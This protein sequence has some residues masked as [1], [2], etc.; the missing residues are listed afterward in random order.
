MPRSLLP[1]VFVL[2]ALALPRAATAQMQ[3]PLAI[4]EAK[5]GE[6]YLGDRE[7][8]GVWRAEAGKL[9]AY[10]QGSKRFR[11]PLNAVRCLVLDREGAL[12]VGDTSTREVYRFDKDAKPVPLTQGGIGIP[13]GIAVNGK[14]ELLVS[15]LELHRI[16][17]VPEKGGKPELLAEVQA[18]RGVCLDKEER[19]WVVCQEK[20]RQLV[21]VAPDGTVETVVDGRPFQFPHNVVVGTDNWAYVTDGYAKAVWRIAP[22]EKPQKWVSG[23]PLKNPV[24]M[25]LGKSGLLVVDPHAKAVFQIDASGNLTRVELAA[26]K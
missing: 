24:G 13:M 12:L 15:D 19:L 9:S 21:R 20:N 17:K 22:G 8:P 1:A 3:Y 16:W 7:L 10:F 23:E 5:S 6:L 4:A 18:P 11:T 2:S 14:G 25:A 26:G